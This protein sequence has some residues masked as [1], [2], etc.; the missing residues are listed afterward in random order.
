[1]QDTRGE[2]VFYGVNYVLMALVGLSTLLPFVHVIAKSFSGDAYVIAGTVGLWPLGANINAY[3]FA[4]NNTPV[5]R[6]FENTLFITS[7]GTALS[8]LVESAAAYPLSLTQFRARKPF[9]LFF[10][11]TMLFSSGLIPAFLLMRSLGLLNNLWSMILPH[12]L[13]AFNLIL[14]KNYYEGLPDAIRESAMIDGANHITTLYRIILPMSVPILAT[15]A[16]FSAVG[17]WNSYFNAMLYLSDPQKVTLQLFLVNLV[18]Q[19]N[20][21]D[22]ITSEVIVPPNTVRSAAVVIGTLPILMVYP[23]VQRYFIT[24]ITL[25]S[26]KG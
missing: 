7:V 14:L 24:G 23:F 4:F 11:F 15:I 22:S 18:R 2:K 3:R 12:L 16:L 9:M 21:T 5:L 6:A 13:S 26:V 8:L 19:A 25:G 10:V 1:M 20:L 17:F